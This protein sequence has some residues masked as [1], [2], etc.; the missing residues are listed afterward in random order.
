MY[1][2][3]QF[4][5]IKHWAAWKARQ[6]NYLGHP[7]TDGRH[8]ASVM[9]HGQRHGPLTEVLINRP[10]GHP[11]DINNR[12]RKKVSSFSWPYVQLQ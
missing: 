4:S 5:H 12:V 1:L 9:R 6:I 11:A 3:T 7:N 2:E 8:V 10:D